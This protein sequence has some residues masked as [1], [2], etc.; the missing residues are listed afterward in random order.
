MSIQ[1][2]IENYTKSFGSH[3]VLHDVDLTIPAG[4]FV[5]LVGKSGCGKSTLLRSVAGLEAP[6]TGQILLDGDRVE[7]PHDQLRMMFQDDR[8]LA[9]RTVLRNVEIAAAAKSGAEENLA[10]VGLA[11]KLEQWPA[12]LSGGQRQRVALA[13]ALSSSPEVI[14]FDEPLGA[15]DALTRLEMQNLIETLWQQRGFTSML[16]THDVAEAVALADRVIVLADG[17]VGLDLEIDLPRPR[18]RNADFLEY[19]N[20]L[21]DS[22]L[23]GPERNH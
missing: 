15:L 19:E 2:T 4:Q 6:T 14:L 9:W 11:D 8:L 5:A 18:T 13:R 16:V 22:I 7:R 1:I 10:A 12:N 21:L 17:G 23:N 20:A 3:T